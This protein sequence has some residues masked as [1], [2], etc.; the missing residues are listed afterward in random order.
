MI[1]FL[2]FF[3]IEVMASS[4]FIGA[5]GGLNFFFEIVLTAVLG[6]IMLGNFKNSIAEN[7]ESLVKRQIDYGQFISMG[8][9]TL[10]GSILL[11]IPGLFTD[12]LGLLLQIEIIG[13]TITKQYEKKHGP[14]NKGQQKNQNTQEGNTHDIIDVEV[15]DDEQDISSTPRLKP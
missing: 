12:V 1:Y 6:A 2:L 15:I 10:L 11:I 8:L 14:I 5:F 7:L 3:F 9:F 13:S 4:E